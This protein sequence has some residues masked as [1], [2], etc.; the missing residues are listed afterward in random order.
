M[1]GADLIEES[2]AVGAGHHDVGEDEVVVGVLRKARHC[3][4]CA[5]CCGCGVAAL[6]EQGR[7]YLSDGL[8]V[9]DYQDSFLPH[10]SSIG[11][12]DDFRK[13]FLRLGRRVSGVFGD[14]FEGGRAKSDGFLMVVSWFLG[15]F[16]GR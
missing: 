1:V 5:V 15:A 3:C 9:V 12:G 14:F 11:G 2:E 10:D 6:L 8:F 13:F 7:D 16:H 4:F